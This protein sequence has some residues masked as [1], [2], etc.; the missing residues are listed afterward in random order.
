MLTASLI[1]NQGNFVYALDDPYIHMTIA[2]NFVTHGTWAANHLSFT[3]ATS[4]PLWTL[5]ISIVYFIFGVN[6]ITPFILNIIFGIFAILIAY[7]ILKENNVEKYLLLILLAVI[8]FSPMPTILFT[9]MEHTAQIAVTLLFLFL[10]TKL[11]VSGGKN[12]KLPMTLV[13]ITPI[14]TG[15]RYESMFIVAVVC[16]LLAIRKKWL[17]S[18][19]IAI[20]GA[21]P[22][23][24]YGIISVSHGWFFFPNPV[25]LKS[26]LPDLTPIEMM[27]VFFRAYK[28]ITEPQILI[29]VGTG[30][31]V[32]WVNYRDNKSLW[33]QK[34]VML[35]IFTLTTILH[36]VFAQNGWFY[37]YEA[38]IIALG[39]LAISIGI[40]EHIR[41]DTLTGEGNRSKTYYIL[42]SSLIFIIMLPLILR[43]LT[44][45]ITPPATNNIYDQHYQM[46]MFVRNYNTW[47]NV[48]ANDIGIISFYS[49]NEILDLWGLAD[50]NAAAERLRKTYDTEKILELTKQKNIKLAILYEHWFDQYGGLPASWIKLGEW[51]ITDYN[52]VCG[53]NTVTFYATDKSEADSLKKKLEEFSLK[54][55]GSVTYTIFD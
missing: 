3:S 12:P 26:N 33:H 24:I 30:L 11:I 43:A 25:L 38:Y 37:R 1:M 21:S 9:G 5:V 36:M 44:A 39:V 8:Y 10:S 23:L 34:Q 22:V 46:G 19:L 2:K 28:N 42:R 47:I 15:L 31:L 20:I 41:K 27:R 4:S 17:L 40:Y 53:A 7:H 13:L 29:L 50:I 52:I 49:E 54:L 35:I 6:L 16:V 48:A 32:L 14:M 55:P 18:L 45:L 51:T